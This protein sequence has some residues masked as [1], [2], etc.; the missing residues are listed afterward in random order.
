MNYYFQG[1]HIL[2]RLD[3]SV[4]GV[5][6]SAQSPEELHFTSVIKHLHNGQMELLNVDRLSSFSQYSSCTPPG[7]NPRFC[8]CDLSRDTQIHY[9]EGTNESLTFNLAHFLVHS[10]QIILSRMTEKY[11]IVDKDETNCIFILIRRHAVGASFEIAN[12]CRDVYY[13]VTFNL[14][15]I[16]M[17]VSTSLPITVDCKPTQVTFVVT[18]HQQHDHLPWRWVY[19]VSH[20]LYTN[21]MDK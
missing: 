1:K 19:S 5:S 15:V 18:C 17:D 16:N 13:H 20:N 11:L 6:S 14:D 7:V 21:N 10:S 4:N 12:R 8:L 2:Y 3:I 9:Q